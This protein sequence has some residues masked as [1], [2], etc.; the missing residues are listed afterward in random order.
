MKLNAAIFCWIFFMGVTAIC[1]LNGWPDWE[2]V[3]RY[4]ALINLVFILIL[5]RQKKEQ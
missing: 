3:F 2:Q 1:K 4:I 5:W